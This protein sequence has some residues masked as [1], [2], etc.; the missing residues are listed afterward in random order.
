MVPTAA[1]PPATPSTDHV[2]APPPGTVAA[3]CCVRDSVMAAILGDT[4]TVP[5]EMVTVAVAM[6]LVPPGP[7]QVNEYAVVAA[8]GVVLNVPLVARGP[9]QPPEAVQEVALIELHV[10]VDVPPLVMTEG[11]AV[12]VAR[13]T[14]LTVT[15]E[16]AEAPPGPVHD[17]E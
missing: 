15:L 1:L 5:S 7:T 11:L 14:T 2:A 3:N 4:A 9:L 12:S 6:A 10:S 16:T 17:R 13:G 8:S